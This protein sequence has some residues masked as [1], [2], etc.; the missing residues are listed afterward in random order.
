[1][2]TLITCLSAMILMLGMVNEAQAK[3]FG[4]GGFGKST[5]TTPQRAAP[6]KQTDKNQQQQAAP[7]RTGLMGGMLG[8]LLAGGLFAYL[9][10]SGAF[11]GIQLMDILLLVGLFFL[12]SRLLRPAPQQRQAAAVGVGQGHFFQQ[13]EAMAGSAAGAVPMNLPDGFDADAFIAGALD[14]YRLVQQ[15]WNEGNLELIREY[16]SPALFDA[17]SAQRNRLMVP[18]QTEILDLDCDIVRAD[19]TPSHR[20]ISLLFRGRCKDDLEKSEDGIFDIWHLERDMASNDAPWIVVGI[21]A[22]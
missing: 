7:A 11:E 20:E 4:S 22:E 17:L 21:E 15:A 8:G 14:H 13:E 6:A 12:I 10:G 16:V 5:P 9:L 2:K 19:E 1:M 18:P 3:R